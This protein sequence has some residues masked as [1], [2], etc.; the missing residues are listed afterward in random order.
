MTLASRLRSWL[1]AAFFRS[2]LESEM[3]SELRFHL[4]AYAADL[5]RSGESQE[6]AARRARVE[7]GG[8]ESAK[9]ECREARGLIFLETL[10]QDLRYGARTLRK[11]PG[12]ALVAVLTLA[13]GIGSTAAVFSVISG[14]LLKPLPYPRADRIITP[15][16]AWPLSDLGTD[17]PWGLR[18]FQAFRRNQNTLQSLGAFKAESFNFTGVGDPLRLDG[19][20]ASAGFFPALGISPLIGRTFTSEEENPGH[21][22]EVVLSYRLWLERFGG[23][24]SALGRSI[25]LSGYSYTVIGVMP[26]GF[27]FPRGE[28]MPSVLGFPRQAQLWV[29]LTTPLNPAGPQDLAVVARLKD[30]VTISQAFAELQVYG[31][32]VEAQIPQAKGYYTPTVKLLVAQVTGDTR[33][34]LLLLFGAVATVLLVACSNVANLLLA[35]S[36]LRRKEFVL[37]SALGAGRGRLLRQLLV[38]NLLLAGTG[39]LV[40]TLFAWAGVYFAKAFG[41]ANLPRLNEVTLDVRVFAFVLGAALLTG[42]LFGLPPAFAGTRDSSADSLKDRTQGAAS[43]PTRLLST[44]LVSQV[45]LALVLVVAAGLL[46]RTFYSLL[47]TDA[48]FNPSRVF[49]FQLTLPA[50]K[51]SDVDVMARVYRDVW[52]ELRS[53]SGV[54]QVGFA[55]AVPLGGAPDGT[56]IRIPD[57]PVTSAKDTPPFANYLFATPGYFAAVGTPLLRGREFTEFD[58]Q[59][60][61]HVTIVTAAMAKAFWPGQD[62]IGRKVGVGL[63]RFP[64]RVIVGMVADTKH[65]SLSEKS[66]PEMYVPYTQNEIKVWPSMQTMQVAL[67]TTQDPATISGV[68]RHALDSVDPDLPLAKPATLASLVDDSVVQPRFSMLL[69]ASFGVVALFLASIGMYGVISYSVLQRTQEIGV[70][71]ALG[72]ERP[73]IF[74]MIVGQGARLAGIG[75]AV[76]LAVAFAVTRLMASFLYGVRATDPLTFVGVS[77]LLAAV[78]LLA[79]YLPA[80]RATRVDPIIALRYE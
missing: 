54:Q 3:D 74:A 40:G 67:R 56:G 35:R 37:R 36:L 9:E 16:W 48:G 78:A 53:I 20:R 32:S 71:M 22:L 68:I 15:W 4:D 25:E 60:S 10:T 17:F 13:L 34:P 49:T 80:R 77:L 42:I 76:G 27:V 7:F 28:E 46:I 52:R 14:V 64:L 26:P 1:R 23:D 41:P 39:G 47:R 18:D 57:R 73:A 75:I 29:P 33:R 51:Y 58:T 79:C 30:G 38:E 19:I 55:S 72:A 59:E 12:F 66:S 61:Q 2:R 69:L 21:E 70:R 31:K 5:V 50:G 8:M 43:R 65:V 11:N 44:L 24:R 45:A 6:E 62:P 63:T